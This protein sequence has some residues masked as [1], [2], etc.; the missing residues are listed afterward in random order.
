MK[1]AIRKVYP[2][3]FLGKSQKCPKKA[4]NAKPKMNF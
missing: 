4:K 2:R 3:T 1:T